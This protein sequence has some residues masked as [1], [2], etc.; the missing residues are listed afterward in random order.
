[1]SPLDLQRL[2]PSISLNRVQIVDL[3]GLDPAIVPQVK[4]KT[5]SQLVSATVLAQLI[6]QRAERLQLN[7]HLDDHALCMVLDQCLTSPDVAVRTAAEAIGQ[8]IGRNLGYVLLALHRGD[9][10]N[11]AA[12]AEW[13][14]SYWDH[15][16][17][18]KRVWLGGGLVSGWLGPL[19]SKGTEALVRAAGVDDYA[20]QVSPHAA[21]LPLLGAARYAPP[22]CQTAL[23]LDF[24]Q[25]MIKCARAI[26]ENDAL[27]ELRL[28][29]PH[30]T[31]WD[32]IKQASDD[33]VQQATRLFNRIVSVVATNWHSA[34]MPPSSPILASVAAYVQDGHPV[35]ARG[36]YGQLRHITDNL[37]TELGRRL[38]AQL[39]DAVDI[40]LIHDGTA[41][42]A[43]YAGAKNTAVIMMGTA[44]GIGFPPQVDDLRA[45]RFKLMA[46][47]DNSSH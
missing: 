5:A 19:V 15:W 39:G 17:G 34:G 30:P 45:I 9:A 12:R 22:A 32:E 40:S 46:K 1:M 8:R 10:L 25:T 29:P 43:T 33:P 35:V 31:R 23:V 47:E 7:P 24:G 3:P 20:V 4:G 11:R 16:H 38:G 26:Y 27:V 13:D 41:A 36:A 18:I 42:A 14:D 44:L 6:R 2:T 21:A 28:L 37:Q